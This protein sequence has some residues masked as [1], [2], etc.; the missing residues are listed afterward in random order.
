MT[1]QRTGRKY[2]RACACGRA[3][4]QR[5]PTCAHCA[6]D[7]LSQMFVY[8]RGFGMMLV[9]PPERTIN[10]REQWHSQVL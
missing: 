6:E 10:R 9:T 4:L 8:V 1:L 3:A 5:Q 2:F 7:R